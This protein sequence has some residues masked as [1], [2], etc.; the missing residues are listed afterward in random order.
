LI[1]IGDA[2]PL[3]VE[4]AGDRGVLAGDLVHAVEMASQ[5]AEP[6]DTVLLAPGC[7]SFDQ[8]E[9]Y[10]SRGEKFSQL[11]RNI[12]EEAPAR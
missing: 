6:G 2:G 8:F 7:A 5:L 11:V 4:A 9:S 1:G 10:Q 12:T 3:L